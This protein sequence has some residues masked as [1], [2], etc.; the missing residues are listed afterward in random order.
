M[1]VFSNAHIARDAIQHLLYPDIIPEIV[2][3]NTVALLAQE[4]S[5]PSSNFGDASGHWT[6]PVLERIL[7][8]RGYMCC[9]AQTTSSWHL[10]SPKYLC[11]NPGLVGF[12][13]ECQM[14]SYRGTDRKWKCQ[15]GEIVEKLPNGTIW[16]IHKKWTPLEQFYKKRMPFS[17]STREIPWKKYEAEPTSCWHAVPISYKGREKAVSR[18]LSKWK[19]PSNILMSNDSEMVM[20]TPTKKGWK[21]TGVLNYECMAPSDISRKVTERLIDSYVTNIEMGNIEHGWSSMAHAIFGLMQ[22]YKI[23]VTPQSF[24]DL[25]VEE[26]EELKQYEKNMIKAT[27]KM[28]NTE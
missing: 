15:N 16:A 3:H 24:S 9:L 1:S 5:T 6:M 20:C 19:L 4:T 14:L 8:D 27:K 7:N 26:Q 12:L 10:D 17:I 18:Q 22:F 21:T 11:K 2:F 23:H 13:H 25:T 28:Q